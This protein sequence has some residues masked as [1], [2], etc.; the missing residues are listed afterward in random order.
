MSPILDLYTPEELK[1]VRLADKYFELD[2]IYGDIDD[3]YYK[4][5]EQA[6]EGLRKN[7][8]D[9]YIILYDRYFF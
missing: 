7:Y 3:R 1:L 9:T 8:Y 2:K 4:V 5:F 6:M